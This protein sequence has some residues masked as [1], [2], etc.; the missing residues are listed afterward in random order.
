M[1]GG[2]L[3]RTSWARVLGSAASRSAVAMSRRMAI[4]RTSR[5]VVAGAGSIG[6]YVGGCLA[7]AGRRRGVAAAAAS[8]GRHRPARPAHLR[9]RGR[10]PDAGAPA[11]DADHR[12][13]AALDGG[14]DHARHRQER[15]HGGDGGADC[16]SCAVRRRRRQPAERRRQPRRA[17]RA[18][19]R[20]AQAVVHGM[21]PFNVVQT[22]ADGRSAALPSRDQRHAADRR[23]RSRACATLLDVPGVRRGRARRHGGVLWGKLVLNLNN[24]LNALRGLPLAQELADARWRRCSPRRSRRRSPC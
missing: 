17:A 19:R 21:V 13:G 8:G 1:Q 9:P 6:C 24:A 4:D 15:R 5:I 3:R 18:P 7:L 22:R 12:P 20:I 11:L 23:R 16:P 10:R 14:P 2:A